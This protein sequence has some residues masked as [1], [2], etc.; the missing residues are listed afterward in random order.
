MSHMPQS[1][2]TNDLLSLLCEANQCWHSEYVPEPG[3]CSHCQ[4]QQDRGPDR[5]HSR[6]ANRQRG[7]GEKKE[8]ER[9]GEERER[10]RERG[11]GG[12]ER[13][14]ER[15]VTERLRDSEGDGKGRQTQIKSQRDTK[16]ARGQNKQKQ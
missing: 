2:P 15:D 3:G 9:K 7:K 14:L 13:E 4:R 11:R 5:G 1:E 12:R 6:N 10:E 16:I 8:G